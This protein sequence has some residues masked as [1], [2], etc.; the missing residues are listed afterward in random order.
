VGSTS[1][2]AVPVR[3]GVEPVFLCNFLDDVEAI[4]DLPE[5]GCAGAGLLNMAGG[6]KCMLSRD[7]RF[8]R[9]ECELSLVAFD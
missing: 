9:G 2:L 6:R 4:F 1:P 5:G 8:V 3:S 7:L